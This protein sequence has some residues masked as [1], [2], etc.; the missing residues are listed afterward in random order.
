M[1][2]E[3]LVTPQG[4][5]PGQ[6]QGRT[7][8]VIDILRAGTTMCAAIHHGAKAVIPAPSSDE[9]IRLA[10]A[11]DPSD[12]LLTG[13][14]NCLRIP[15]FA[16]GNS[17]LEMTKDVVQG[18]TLIMTTTNGTRALLATQGAS[19]VYSAAAANITAA[20]ER[21]REIFERDR[22]LLIV[23][24]GR[25]NQFALDDAFCAGRLLLGILGR[26]RRRQ[27]LN[28]AALACVSLTRRYG[29]RWERP[30]RTS[31]G[32]RELV[33]LGFREDVLDAARPDAYP[34][35]LKFHDRRVTADDSQ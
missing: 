3:V 11:L 10:Q 2:L 23:C 1:S 25:E 30:L 22:D 17:P 12:V 9:A 33:R 13:E 19:V 28:D 16:L 34:V 29:E 24:A 15:G 20:A 7:V 27:G 26:R 32:G 21:A 4:I 14:R 5:G 18:K 8:F 35:L 31:E 6:T